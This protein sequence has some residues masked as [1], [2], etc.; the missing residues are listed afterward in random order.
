VTQAIK[1]HIASIARE[2]GYPEEA[3]QMTPAQQQDVWWALDETIRERDY[4]LWRVK[5]VNDWLNGVWA[6]VYGKMYAVV[7]TPTLKIRDVSRVAGPLML[8]AWIAL[9]WWRRKR[10]G[11]AA[12]ALP[13]LQPQ[14]AL[15]TGKLPG[16]EDD[17]R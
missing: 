13:P 3:D 9:A 8:M 14:L 5:Q 6:Q 15:E 10:A 7:I 12:A 2:M 17:P 1:P 16:P 4:E 11:D